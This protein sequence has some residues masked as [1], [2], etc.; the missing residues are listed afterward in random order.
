MSGMSVN[1][2]LTIEPS[3]RFEEIDAAMIALS[4]KETKEMGC[5]DL[6]GL[7]VT[8]EQRSWTGYLNSSASMLPQS[9]LAL[10]REYPEVLF[11]LEGDII[12]DERAVR[13]YAKNGKSFCAVGEVIVEKKYP[14][15]E[16]WM[17]GTP[18]EDSMA[19]FSF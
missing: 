7:E 16:E 10:S 4:D 1:L 8:P 5:S 12:I 18:T 14:A 15:F 6:D 13:L 2:E 19:E 11:C 17:L 3:D 9:I